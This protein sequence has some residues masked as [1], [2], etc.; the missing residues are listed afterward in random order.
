[1]KIT[2]VALAGASP[3]KVETPGEKVDNSR[4]TAPLQEATA[5]EEGK[6][7]DKKVR[8][9]EILSKIKALTD[10]GAFSVRFEMHAKTRQLVARVVD[11][12]SGE[13]IRQ[14]PPEEML[15]LA[16]R[17]EELSGNIVNARN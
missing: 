9:E 14:L 4:K 12:E 7:Q 16:A 3:A 8:S 6:G 5:P 15:E 1:M 17:L 13:V 2:A 10:D 11:S